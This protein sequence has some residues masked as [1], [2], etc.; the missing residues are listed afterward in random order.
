MAFSIIII[1]ATILF[2]LFNFG[3]ILITWY[4][5]FS[6]MNIDGKLKIGIKNKIKTFIGLLRSLRKR[7]YII[8]LL[9]VSAF[10][11]LDGFIAYKVIKPYSVSHMADILVLGK[12]HRNVDDLLN[13]ISRE[14]QNFG[15]ITQI[16]M[17]AIK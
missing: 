11:G 3:A 10:I 13:N 17:L 8:A 2:F 14:I 16:L 6:D 7:T 9:I 15:N 1:L 4:M 12:L 5:F